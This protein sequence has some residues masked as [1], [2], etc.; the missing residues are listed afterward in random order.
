M[1][2]IPREYGL[3]KEGI[4]MNEMSVEAKYRPVVVCGLPKARFEKYGVEWPENWDVR[5]T[6][7][8][9]SPEVMKDADYLLSDSMDDID[10][11]IL[12]SAPHLKVAH[13]EG[14][15]FDRIDAKRAAELG[16]CVCNNRAVNK[17]SVAEF[18]IGLLVAGYKRINILDHKI[19]KEGYPAANQAFLNMGI[20]DLEGKR[21]GMIGMGAIGRE[22]L[23]RLQGWGC[24]L[25]YYDPFRMPHEMELE[26]HLTY[27]EFDELIRTSDI[28][29][30]HL[31]VNP[32]TEGMIGKK[33]FQ[34]MKNTAVLVNVARGAVIDDNA[35]VWALENNEIGFAALDTV[36]PE[37]MP[38]DHVLLTMS[39]DA[40][41]KLILT[42]HCAGRTA[43]AFRRMLEWSIRDFQM[44]ED[45]K[46]PNNVVNGVKAVRA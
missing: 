19:R 35:L 16:I 10:A 17:G 22:V 2:S 38:S 15:S 43:D 45:G 46:L 6:D 9:Y 20:G 5:Y 3:E 32:S 41:E 25:C 18:C 24:D 26:K 14:V 4:I 23:G 34:E 39:K 44:A 1:W 31:P 33:Q 28:I 21:I 13:A 12:E 42:T 27:L 11:S 30:I 29:T 8:V 37:P 7:R 36:D 40:E